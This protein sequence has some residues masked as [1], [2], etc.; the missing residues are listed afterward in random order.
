MQSKLQRKRD[1]PKRHKTKHYFDEEK[2]FRISFE[3][4]LEG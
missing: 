3:S 4:G 2:N 1:I